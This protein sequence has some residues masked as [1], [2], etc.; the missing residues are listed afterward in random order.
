MLRAYPGRS[1]GLLHQP[2]PVLSPSD[3]T[4]DSHIGHRQLL[5]GPWER[6]NGF[7][8]QL[9]QPALNMRPALGWRGWRADARRIAVAVREEHPRE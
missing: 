7:V 9:R 3:D 5:V 1:A 4:L 8:A 2:V 6:S